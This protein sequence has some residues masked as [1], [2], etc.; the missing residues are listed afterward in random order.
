[1]FYGKIIAG[2]IGLFTF[3]PIGLLLGLAAGHF[4]DTGLARANLFASPEHLQRVQQSFFETSF[5]L[6]GYMAKSDGNISDEEI[7]HTEN[8]ISQLQLNPQ[9]RQ[10]ALKLFDQGAAEG[11]ELENTLYAFVELC[12]AHARLKHTLLMFLMS[13]ALAD[14]QL[15]EGE[16]NAL[17]R[18]GSILGFGSAQLENLLNMARAQES[19]HQQSG[20]RPNTTSLADAYAALGV[21]ESDSDQQIKRAYR[22]L[23]SEN[24]P[25]KLIAQGVPEDM[26]KIGTE[27]SQEIQA[28]YEL[29]KKQRR[30]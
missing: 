7:Q 17:L 5:L 12:G 28:A 6:L 21:Q 26:L 3:G 18:I 9:Q 25:D 10:E 20:G 29:I 23:M 30:G 19:F 13:L 2:L 16:H 11:F 22:K 14:Q 1:V 15:D 8:I 27:K 24:H 4:F